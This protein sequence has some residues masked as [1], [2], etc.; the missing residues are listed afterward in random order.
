MR[1]KTSLAIIIF[2]ISAHL[3][4]LEGK[5]KVTEVKLKDRPSVTPAA[6]YYQGNRSP[7]LPGPLVKLPV[8]QIEVRG[9]LLSQLQLM[10]SGFVGHLPEISRF[11]KED[12]G[13]LSLQGKGWEEMPYWLKGYGDLAYLL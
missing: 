5:D 10:R 4:F 9:W 12:S 6:G 1:K 2:L 7:L 3:T 11:L 13:W 8:G